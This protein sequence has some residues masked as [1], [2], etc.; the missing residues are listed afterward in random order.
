MSGLAQSQ[1][2]RQGTLIVGKTV[3]PGAAEQPALDLSELKF[4]FNI[5]QQDATTPNTATIRVY[6]LAEQTAQL[7]QTEFSR[8]VLQA[9]Y[10]YTTS[11]IIFDGTIVQTRKGRERNVDSYLDI[12]AAEG[13]LP[14]QFAVVNKTLA[15]GS[16]P[17][18]QANAISEALKP[19]NLTIGNDAGLVGGTLP[20]GKVLFGMALAHLDQLTETTGSTWVIQ[21][22]QINVVP[23]TG[24]LAGEAVQLNSSTGLIGTPE[25]TQ[26]GIKLQCLINPKIRLGGRIQINNRDINTVIN[27]GP[28][29]ASPVNPFGGAFASVTADGFYRVVVIEY[30]GDSRGEPWYQNIIALAIDQ[31]APADKSVKMYP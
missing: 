21:R 31:S 4:H 20:R 25:A 13:T 19:Y 2:L 14:Y 28:P 29:L 22:G 16:T 30:E 1:W 6:N 26:E 10:K 11:G 8:V 5:R 23:L 18:D 27:R 7:I 15:P 9:G 3:D 24:Y 12:M 17:K